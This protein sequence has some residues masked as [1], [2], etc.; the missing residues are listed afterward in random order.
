MRARWLGSETTGSEKPSR[1]TRCEQRAGTRSTYRSSAWG[2]GFGSPSRWREAWWVML[3]SLGWEVE[4]RSVGW[5]VGLRPRSS[6]TS[7]PRSAFRCCAL[8]STSARMNPHHQPNSQ[9][10]S[11]T[12]LQEERRDVGACAG[13]RKLKSATEGLHLA[14]CRFADAV[15]VVHFSR[16]HVLQRPLRS[17]Q[18]R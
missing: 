17:S 14:R 12:R 11:R 10:P 4:L 9:F 18:A 8:P 1:R 6:P 2:L 3:R 7:I 13:R 5:E 15:Y 16:R